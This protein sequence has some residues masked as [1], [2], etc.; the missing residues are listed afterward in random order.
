MKRPRTAGRRRR[1]PLRSGGYFGRKGK[2]E[3]KAFDTILNTSI[4][5]L[6]TASNDSDS[7]YAITTLN[8]MVQGSDFNERIGRQINM[9]KFVQKMWIQQNDFAHAGIVRIMLVYDLQTNAAVFQIGDLLQ[10]QATSL[11]IHALQNLDNR[12]RFKILYDKQ[13]HF[14]KGVFAD[15]GDHSAARTTYEILGG[16]NRT[17]RFIKH[18]K[19]FRLPVVYNSTNAGSIGDIQTGSLHLV[20]LS[21]I[22]TGDTHGAP[23]N[24]VDFFTQIRV[25]YYDG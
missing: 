12:D 19:K 14:E 25:R 1:A 22:K 4:S 18:F 5:P 16:S 7:V 11:K 6:P 10:L 20:V 13:Y 24:P 23:Q 21:N 9:R 2:V 8:A 17:H 3:L 15:S